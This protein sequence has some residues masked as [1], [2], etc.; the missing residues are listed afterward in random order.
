MCAAVLRL[1]EY[2]NADTIALLKAL[3]IGATNGDVVGLDLKARI[4]GGGEKRL[5]TGPYREIAPEP[6]GLRRWRDL[7]D[8]SS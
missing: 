6:C 3:L 8:T 5:T 7:D 1:V 4:R 2:R